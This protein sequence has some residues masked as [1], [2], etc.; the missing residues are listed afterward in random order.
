M[1]DEAFHHKFGKIWADRTVPKLSAEEHAKVED[2]AAKCFQTLLFN[3]VNS[4]QKQQIYG[5]F[6]LDWRWVRSAVLESFGDA[7][8]RDNLRQQTNIFRVLVKTLLKAG[9][10]TD[11]TR[12]VYAAWVD[13]DELSRETDEVVGSDV[14]E[15]AMDELRE[16]NRGRARRMLLRPRPA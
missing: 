12:P 4:E 16:I 1:S 5:E 11:R 10:I 8:R 9:I 7:D 2:W 3:L 15:A 6:G 13:L 14:A